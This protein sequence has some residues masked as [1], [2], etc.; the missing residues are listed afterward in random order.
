[1]GPP[2]VI[3]DVFNRLAPGLCEVIAKCDAQFCDQLG[4][5]NLLS[6]VEFDH[7]LDPPSMSQLG[8]GDLSE[9]TTMMLVAIIA[10]VPY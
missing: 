5:G 9:I 6:Y 7:D 3:D 1:M 4:K 8:G 10:S 2:E